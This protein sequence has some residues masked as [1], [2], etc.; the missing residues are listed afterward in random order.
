MLLFS[1]IPEQITLLLLGNKW[2]NVTPFL[3]YVGILIFSQCP[4]NILGNVFLLSNKEKYLTRVALMNTF[5]T[6]TGIII[7]LFTSF[8]AV[9]KFYTLFYVF[10]SLPLTVYITYHIVLKN[11]INSFMKYWILKITVIWV[12]FFMINTPLQKSYLLWL[13]L[14]LIF[15][16]HL[17]I[18]E[19][20][21]IFRYMTNT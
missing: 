11:A 17:F 10:L 15:Y 9:I 19:R 13:I 4:S 16:L 14:S 8:L 21:L 6:A 12:V 1:L 7:G 2:V 5:F 3:P 20:K 18:N